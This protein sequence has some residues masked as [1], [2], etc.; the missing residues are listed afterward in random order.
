MS[1][2]TRGVSESPRGAS[3][4]GKSHLGARLVLLPRGGARAVAAGRVR[5][6]RERARGRSAKEVVVGQLVASQVSDEV[7]VMA[8]D[9]PPPVSVIDDMAFLS[10]AVRTA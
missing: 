8:V 2:S 6:E 4:R 7:C 5:V 9:V 10:A 1:E 3:E